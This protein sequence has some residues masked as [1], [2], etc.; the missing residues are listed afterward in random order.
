MDA[1]SVVLALILKLV[2]ENDLAEEAWQNEAMQGLYESLANI[3]TTYEIHGNGSEADSRAAAAA[4]QNQDAQASP[5]SSKQWATIAMDLVPSFKLG[6]AS[7]EEVNSLLSSLTQVLAKY[8]DRPD[9]QATADG[10]DSENKK[11]LTR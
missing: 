2:R 5:V 7:K 9:V 1:G 6:Q 10:K 3:I 11:A 8:N 4:Q